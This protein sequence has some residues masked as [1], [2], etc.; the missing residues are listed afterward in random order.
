MKRAFVLIK[1]KL[2]LY[3]KHGFVNIQKDYLLSEMNI[4]HGNS[5]ETLQVRSLDDLLEPM[6]RD[7]VLNL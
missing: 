7:M 4:D 6:L 1:L 2:T 5:L 3:P